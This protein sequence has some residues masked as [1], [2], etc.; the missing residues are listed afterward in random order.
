V[1]LAL[2]G[3]GDEAGKRKARASGKSAPTERPAEVRLEKIGDFDQP[4]YVAEAPGSDDLYAVEKPGRVQRV[5]D[6]ETQTAL[7]ISEEVSD[8]SEQGLLSIAFAPDFESSK[9]VYVY[10]TDA[11]QNQRIVEY[12]VEDGKFDPDSRREVLRMVD[13]AS[14]HN[15]GLLLFGPDGHLYI[16]T[17]DGG[18]IGDPKRNGQN[19]GSLLGKI[20]RI[21]PL[22]DGKRPYS[23]PED[24]PFTDRA[25]ARPEIWAYGLR[26]PWRFSFDRQ[27]GAL[28]IADVGQSSL[29]EID[30]LPRDAAAGANL[31]WSAFEGTQRFNKD[32]RARGRVVQPVFTYGRDR[33]CSITG[34][35]VVR[36]SELSSLF[37]RYVYGDFCAGEL[38]SLAP[39]KG[40]ARGDRSLGVTVPMLSSFGEDSS[41]RIYATSLNGP[42]FRLVP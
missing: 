6:G 32:Q 29:E 26:N 16:G 22:P 10:F 15:G 40:G 38:R 2:A 9:L 25:G 13:Y 17:G 36:N 5:H 30:Y 23:V 12:R 27:T 19:L 24:N 8:S 31:G 4:L 3:C 35:Y 14:N 20:L 1:A 18:D 39:R 21:D 11:H 34:G 33:G 42:V 7:D 37:G 28:L 41:G